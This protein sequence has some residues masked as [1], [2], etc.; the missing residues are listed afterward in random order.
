MYSYI[1]FFS[2]GIPAIT[3]PISLSS[4]G[5]PLALQLMAPIYQESNLLKM[6]QWLQEAVQFP[7]LKLNM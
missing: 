6:A 2:L 7:H 5:L 1:Y 4:D 3:V